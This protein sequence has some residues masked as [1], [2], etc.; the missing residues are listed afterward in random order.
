MQRLNIPL[1]RHSRTTRH[2]RRVVWI[3]VIFGLI[4]LAVVWRESAT[5]LNRATIFSAAPDGTVAA[6]YLQIN[7]DTIPYI[8]TLLRSVPLVSNRSIELN[9]VIE[10]TRGDVAIFLTASGQRSL[11]IRSNPEVLEGL[12]LEEVGITTQQHGPFVLLSETLV[13]VS[14][15]DISLSKP[16]FPSISSTWIGGIW[17]QEYGQGDIQANNRGIE[18]AFE[19]QKQETSELVLMNDMIAHALLGEQNRNTPPPSY[20]VI[21]PYFSHI[22]EVVVGKNGIL[23]SLEQGTLDENTLTSQL[24]QITALNNPSTLTRTMVDGSSYDEL[25][26]DPA[27]VTV[28]EVSIGGVRVFRSGA[29]LG[30][31]QDGRPV[32]STSEELVEAFVRSDD[33]ETSFCANASIVLDPQSLM[34]SISSDHYDP[35]LASLSFID[36]FSVIYLEK[37][38]YSNVIHLSSQNCG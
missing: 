33:G 27:L 26:I 25:Q 16:F 23:I 34:E 37:K 29:L 19:T 11:A 5:L 24:Q 30:L 6:I 21:F 28:E 14:G 20:E 18:I 1:S 32:I 22:D 8:D 13:P 36:R 7:S 3:L 4:A 35:R 31:L 2:N 9:D 17:V 12:L 10:E 15:T 38:K